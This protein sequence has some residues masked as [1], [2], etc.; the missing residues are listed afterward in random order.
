[1]KIALLMCLTGAG[2]ATTQTVYGSPT[3]AAQPAISQIVITQYTGGGGT[4]PGIDPI[5]RILLRRDGTAIYVG[6]KTYMTRIGR[7]HGKVESKYFQRLADLFQQSS[8]RH[9]KSLY[10]AY[11]DREIA[12]EKFEITYGNKKKSVVSYGAS[13]PQAIRHA[14][15]IVYGLL[16]KIRWHKVSSSDAIAE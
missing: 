9:W 3:K 4:E 10:N 8:F 7:Y 16:W 6:N 2:A 12:S 1:M 5:Y 14:S 13:G 15:K 11:D